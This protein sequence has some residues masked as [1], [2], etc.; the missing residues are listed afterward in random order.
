MNTC[1]DQRRTNQKNGTISTSSTTTTSCYTKRILF[2]SILIQVVKVLL[3]LISGLSSKSESFTTPTTRTT[4]QSGHY[5]TVS[6]L[7]STTTSST[8]ILSLKMCRPTSTPSSNTASAEAAAPPPFNDRPYDLII[9]G[10]TGFTGQIACAYVKE[11]YPN[12][13]VAYAGRNLSKLQNVRSQV[14]GGGSSSNSTSDG[15]DLQL[16]PLIVADA[17]KDPESLD[18]LAAS[19]RVIANYA[20]TPFID[21]ALPVVEA[22][23]KHGT[24]YTDITGEAP[25]QR[26]SYDRYNKLATETGACIVHACG[27]DSVPSDLG[28]FIAAN[29]MKERH[30]CDCTSIELV[31][32][33]GKGGVSG[34]TLHTGMTL[35]FGSKDQKADELPGM[36]EIKARGG[37]CYGLD[38]DGAKGGNDTAD[39]VMMPTYD[40]VA[41]TAVIPFVMAGA[42]APV[43]RKTNAVLNY[44]Y[45]A[46]CSYREVQAVPNLAVGWL[47]MAGFGLFGALIAFPPTRWFLLNY[48]LPKPGEGPSKEI[49]ETGYFVSDIYAVG[50]SKDKPVIHAYVKSGNAGDPGYKA[51]GRMSIEASLCMALQRDLCAKGGVLTPASALGKTL[52]DRLNKTGMELGV[53]AK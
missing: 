28:A 45:G 3:L 9:Y 19:T 17:V 15:K 44:L 50:N 30:G 10:A 46:N 6:K 39:T 38:P 13:K 25:F 16:P 33:P 2:P 26:A 5:N 47:G 20:G 53:T 27:Y 37:N 29:E 18:E 1:T 11:H 49:Q 12:L 24:C 52:V 31:A 51:T 14:Y 34:G 40:E 22:C 23:A 32:Q 4:N 48:V 35:M 8:T 7:S 21:K 43:V 42:N 36:R 41:K